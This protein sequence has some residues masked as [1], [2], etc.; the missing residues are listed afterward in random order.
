MSLDIRELLPKAPRTATIAIASYS[1]S[2]LEQIQADYFVKATDDAAAIVNAAIAALPAAGGEI[3]L[4]SGQF[5]A[6]TLV[7]YPAAGYGGKIVSIRGQGNATYWLYIPGTGNIFEFI[8]GGTNATMCLKNQLRNIQVN[9]PSTTGAMF[10]F[11]WGQF[12]LLDR[13]FLGRIPNGTVIKLAGGCLDNTFTH[14]YQA[15][16]GSGDYAAY[17][18][19]CDNSGAAAACNK[20]VVEFFDFQGDGATC[21]I[22][23]SVGNHN[24]FKSGAIGV[25][26]AA[27]NRILLDG[28]SSGDIF[29]GIY[30]DGAG[31]Q[32][33]SSTGHRFKNIYGGAPSDYVITGADVEIDEIAGTWPGFGS[34]DVPILPAL[35][36]SGLLQS[37]DILLPI[38]SRGVTDGGQLRDYSPH[39][40]HFGIVGTP[41]KGVVT[42]TQW[43]K[44]TFSGAVGQ[45]ARSLI[46]YPL[47]GSNAKTWIVAIIPNFAW[48]ADPVGGNICGW[49]GG[50][51]TDGVILEKGHGPDELYVLAYIGGVSKV[52]TYVPTF[53]A[54]DL[55]ILI[56]V[57]DPPNNRLELYENG[58]SKGLSISPAAAFTA[59]SGY[60]YVAAAY[61]GG[62]GWNGG[63][64]FYAQI[65]KAFSAAEVLEATNE[66]FRVINAAK[67][68][69]SGVLAIPMDA[70]A[71]SKIWPHG[72]RT[73][74]ANVLITPREAAGK[75]SF[76][77]GEDATN[78]TV[79]IPVAIA[80]SAIAVG[81]AV[82][83]DGGV[84]TDETTPANN[85]TANDMTLLPAVPAANDAYDFAGAQMYSG[86]R[87]NMGIPGVGVWTIVW[88]Y[89]NNVG[90]WAALA[91]VVDGTAG[92][93][94]A[95]GNHDVTF[96]I[97]TDWALATVYGKTGY[98]V[99]A[100]VSAY[101]SIVTQPFGTQAWLLDALHFM[102]RA[103]I[104]EG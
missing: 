83:V 22:W 100:R 7:A 38:A 17:Y 98:H 50:V 80:A 46:P 42:A 97:P 16:V 53:A 84:T 72:L 31:L 5:N 26:N 57:L 3:V 44:I 88:E 67:Y 48:N 21:C 76:I 43:P 71:V 79:N 12:C 28:F 37:A 87:I 8:G 2:P 101:T 82:A 27:R 62:Y 23:D 36:V 49:D 86:V 66:L 32:T 18:F 9:A 69:N 52:V 96:T 92:F 14:L 70:A 94:A 65:P 90:V 91:A 4:S 11:K 63:I 85:A 102:W 25:Y 54:G 103:Q 74:P 39:A 13:I 81:A 95:P 89:Y 75:D 104:G 55:L 61:S 51:P 45:Y 35:P 59:A 47:N 58:I 78:F 10:Y 64:A 60:G 34:Q 6:I 68:K 99:R 19:V 20:N 1:A 24:E 73:T 77:N 33:I 29:D 56:A 40:N 93:S 15:R 30:Y 41:T